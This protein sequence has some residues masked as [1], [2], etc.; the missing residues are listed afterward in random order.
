MV[1]VV[2]VVF[3][4]IYAFDFRKNENGYNCGLALAYKLEAGL[5][6]KDASAGTITGKIKWLRH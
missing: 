1:F 5:K 2:F 4:V 3:V 6:G